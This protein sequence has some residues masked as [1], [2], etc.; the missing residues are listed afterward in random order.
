MPGLDPG[1]CKPAGIAAI[2]QQEVDGRVKPGH[3]GEK[4]DGS[5]S[6]HLH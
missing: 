1:I 5:A 6:E 2:C 4:E 3:D